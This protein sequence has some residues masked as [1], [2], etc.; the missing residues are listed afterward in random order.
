LPF[1]R[2]KPVLVIDDNFAIIRIVKALL[3]AQGVNDVEGAGSGPEAIRK[4]SQRPYGLVICDYFMMP[5]NGIDL[6][7]VL[8]RREEFSGIPF[9]LMTT[10]EETFD[11]TKFEKANLRNIILKPFTGDGLMSEIDRIAERAA[12]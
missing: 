2:S 9:L 3:G 8:D 5:M 6:K 7:L 10:K 4:L 12:P 11:R 1:D